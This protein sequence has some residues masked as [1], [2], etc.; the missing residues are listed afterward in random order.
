MTAKKQTRKEN[1][2]P[3]KSLKP[4]GTAILG[5]PGPDRQVAVYHLLVAARKQ[6]FIDVL[7][8]TLKSL[9]QAVVKG[10]MLRYVPADA[11]R[12]LAVAGIRDE[13]IFPVPA[14]LEAKPSLVG[15]YRMLLGAP[16][17]S[18]YKGSTGM[19]PFKTMEEL[20]T[21]SDNQRKLLPSFCK[22]MA[23]VLADLVR[24]IDDITERDVRELPLLTFGTQLQELE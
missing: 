11:L 24:Q 6:W 16:Q 4:R 13:H 19:G 10:E 15:Y 7:W 18:F 9:D 21:I 12:L 14:V 17:K 23:G 2:T 1:K 20:G 3:T 5:P 22:A 8:D